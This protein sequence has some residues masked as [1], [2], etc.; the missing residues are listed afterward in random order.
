MAE[1]QTLRQAV[2]S[3]YEVHTPIFEGPLALLLRLIEKNELDITK[4]ALAKVTDEFMARVDQMRGSQQIE[5]IADFLAVAAKLLWIKSKAL[6]PAPPESANPEDEE[7]DVGDELVRQLRTYRMFKEAAQWL[8]ERDHRALRSYV[9]IAPKPRPKEFHVDIGD[10]T[11]DTL[12]ALAQAQLFPSDQPQPEDAIQRPRISIVQQIKLIQQRLIRWSRVI[13]H[14]LFDAE[15]TRLEAV[16]TL[17]AVLELVKQSA[18]KV[19]QPTLFGE[20]VIE[21]L[22]PPEEISFRQTSSEENGAER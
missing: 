6:L 4:V 18:V 19:S 14:H 22:I 21:A 10:A 20:I 9:S 1:T 11:P 3:D 5:M 13:F 12:R 16:V 7:E 8:R 17:Q 15:T 2:T